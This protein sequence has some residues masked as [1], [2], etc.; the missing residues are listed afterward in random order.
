MIIFIKTIDFHVKFMD[1]RSPP[2]V[3]ASYHCFRITLHLGNSPVLRV[4]LSKQLFFLKI[5]VLLLK[6]GQQ[7]WRHGPLASK[8][9]RQFEKRSRDF[10]SGCWSQ[11]RL[12]CS[13]T[14]W[15]VWKKLL[16]YWTVCWFIKRFVVSQIFH[17]CEEPFVSFGNISLNAKKCLWASEIFY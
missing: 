11:K 17:W 14:G 5:D 4:M 10:K 12:V 13:K 15:S 2:P 3:P 9:V 7:G 6:S 1:C 8:A 16:I